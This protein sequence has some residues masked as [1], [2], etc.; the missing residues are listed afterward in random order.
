MK[1]LT[2]LL[3]VKEHA[4]KNIKNLQGIRARVSLA[5]LVLIVGLGA[6]SPNYAA[7]SLYIGDGSDNTVKRFHADTGAFQGEFVPRFAD[8]PS[9]WQ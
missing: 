9:E 4:M 3:F 8:S 2:L 1:R 5:V 7:D 6:T